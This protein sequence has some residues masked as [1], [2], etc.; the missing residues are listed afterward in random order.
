MLRTIADL[1]GQER[2]ASEH[3]E[4]AIQFADWLLGRLDRQMRVQS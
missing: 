3:V 4:E 2:I 1:A